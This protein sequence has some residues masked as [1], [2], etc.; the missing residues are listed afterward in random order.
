MKK[1]VSLLIMIAMLC[2][3][4]N[5]EA[6]D[7]DALWDLKTAHT[8]DNNAVIHILEEAGAKQYGDY[9]IEL[10]TTTEPY[11]LIIDYKSVNDQASKKALEKV[12]GLAVGL[13]DNLGYV[14]VKTPDKTYHFTEKKLN[15]DFNINVKQMS[16]DKEKLKR[17]L[18]KQS[19]VNQ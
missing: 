8:G 19:K 4:S 9:T 14:D 15:K 10:Q 13:I 7:A 6:G 3:C 5:A 11:G 12:S 1:I 18:E 16:K 17:F 2:A